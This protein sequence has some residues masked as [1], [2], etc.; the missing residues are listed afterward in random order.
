MIYLNDIGYYLAKNEVPN[1]SK[2]DEFSINEDFIFHKIGITT[3]RIKNPEETTSDLCV[4]AYLDLKTKAHFDDEAIDCLIVCTQNPDDYGL[5]HTS[6]LV[7][8]KLGLTQNC[9]VFDISLG[10]SGYVYGLSIAQSFMLTNNLKKG[11]FITADP[12]SNIV[13]PHDKNT[14]LLFGDAATATLISHT[15][16]NAW[17]I[18]KFVF[19]SDGSKNRAIRTDP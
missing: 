11:I 18:G 12:Y 8:G 1:T 9:A 3:R 19:G 5:P 10:C 6:A 16:Q 4:N 13:D 7:H 17:K 14:A 2:M 15:Q